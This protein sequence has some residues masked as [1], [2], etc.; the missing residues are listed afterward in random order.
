MTDMFQ[1]SQPIYS[2]LAERIKKQILRGELKPGD[3]LPS[4]REMGIQASV[5]PNTV[6]RTYREL[7]GMKIVETKRGQG[8]FVTEN[9]QT[10]HEMRE[11]LKEVEIS[12]FV[13]GMHEMGYVDDEIEAGLKAFLK[14]GKVVE[15]D[16]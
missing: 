15:F 16:D 14:N 12:A 10:L 9:E 13:K 8:T 3:K 5:N 6:Q 1:S 2:Q 11:Q 4:V 7:E